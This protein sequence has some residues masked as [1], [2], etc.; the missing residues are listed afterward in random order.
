MATTLADYDWVTVL[1]LTDTAI[2]TLRAVRPSSI[3]D[4]ENSSR[5]VILPAETTELNPPTPAVAEDEFD[6]VSLDGSPFEPQDY[7]RPRISPNLPDSTVTVMVSEGV[8][9][10]AGFRFFGAVIPISLYSRTLGFV[11][12]ISIGIAVVAVELLLYSPGAL[13]L[14][15]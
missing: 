5:Y 8:H 9:F 13:I 2:G 3:A 11:M 12:L 10:K 7:E 1:G 14:V 6:I 15:E 4:V